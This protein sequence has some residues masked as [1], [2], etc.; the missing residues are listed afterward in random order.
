VTRWRRCE[1]G[2]VLVATAFTAVQVA[3]VPVRIPLGWDEVVYT[4]QVAVRAPATYFDAPRA[5]GVTLLAAGAA[6]LSPSTAVLRVW[7]S[8][9]AGAGLVIAYWPWRRLLP[10]R[11]VILAPALLAS[12]WIVGFYADEVMPNIYVAYGTVAAVGWFLRATAAPRTSRWTLAALAASI[13]FTALMRPSD[14]AFLAAPLLAAAL[15]V[16]AWRSASL[17]V[18]VVSGLAVGVLPWIIEAYAR[19][20]GPMARLR[21]SSAEQNGMSLHNA[22]GMELRALNGP[23]LCRPCHVPWTH[24]A[25]SLWWFAMPVLA[26]AGVAFAARD[27]ARGR[28]RGGAGRTGHHLDL[29]T[30]LLPTV[31][32]AVASVQYLLLIDYAAPRFLIPTYALLAL[33]IAACLLQFV[34]RAPATLRPAAAGIV[35]LALAAQVLSQYSVLHH[36]ARQQ[37]RSRAQLVDLAQRLNDA[38]LHP[39]CTLAGLDML[40]T[41]FDAGCSWQASPDLTG[42]LTGHEALAVPAGRPGPVLARVWKHC[43]VVLPDHS[44]W[45]LYLTPASDSAWRC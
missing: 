20:G 38:G 41:A 4:S 13:A 14:A 18:S 27:R 2:L 45:E 11:V 17:S 43:S 31:C 37:T 23:I 5:R 1:W 24:P 7:M 12:L 8:L 6:A 21:K 10:G 28:A 19:F 34:G 30:L 3:T 26:F 9:L 35:A 25:L 36:R 15:A 33:P 16:R 22:I 42:G 29:G 39:P 44:A 32:A 40:Q